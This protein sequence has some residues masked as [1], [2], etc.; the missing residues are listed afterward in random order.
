[1]TDQDFL[2]PGEAVDLDNCAREPI[3]V[4][5]RI[6]PRGALLALRTDDTLVTQC[7]KNVGA[8]LGVAPEAVLGRPLAAALGVDAADR[9]LAH[10][11]QVDDPR[12]RNPLD[13]ELV[14]QGVPERFEAVLH[15]APGTATPNRPPALVLELEPFSSD[16]TLSYTSTF[17][18]VRD[19]L[20]ELDHATSLQELYDVAVRRVRRLTGF[21]RV[22]LY[23]FDADYNGE[24]VA[25]ARREDLNAFLGLHYPASDIPPQA[26]ALYEKNWIRLISDVGYTPAEILP[27]DDPVSAQPLDLTYGTLRSVSPIHIEYLQNMGVGASMSISL[28]REGRLWGLIACHHYAGAHAPS[29]AARAAAEFLGSTLSARLVTQAE[30]DRASAARRSAGVLARLAALT[31][32]DDVTLTTALTGTPGLLDL[33]PADGAFVVAEGRIDRL[34]ETPDEQTCLRLGRA[35]AEL[36]VEVLVTDRLAHD[37]PELAG[38]VPD[39]A[40]LLALVVPGGGVTVWLRREVVQSVD[41]GG[42]PHNKAIARRE[43]DTVRLSPRRSF[44]RWREVVRGTSEPWAEDQVDVA[45][46]LRSYLAE[47]LL[48]RGRRDIRAATVLQRSL[49]PTSL[50]EVPGWQVDAR[51]EPSGGG[52]AGGDWYDALVLDDGRVAVVVGDVTGH[53]LAAAATMGQLRN[54]LRALLV[55][56]SSAVRAVEQVDHLLRTTLPGQVATLVVAVVSPGS[57]E[58]EYVTAGH[59]PPVLVGSDGA[60]MVAALGTPPLGVGRREARSGAA[61]VPAGGAVV[62]FSD[63]LVERRDES[64]VDG[65]GRLRAAAVETLDPGEL[66]ARVRDPDSEDDATVVVVRRD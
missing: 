46:S 40:G 33:V 25:E 5:G 8:V 64:I 30:D 23:R 27:T 35:L 50:P 65:L 31:R 13:L 11:A 26:R 17:E 63:G 66:V 18:P 38:I 6:Q 14:V 20:T 1:M 9:L 24:V 56:G 32:D 44:A 49:L 12:Q 62:L 10:V 41:W 58:V 48:L 3:H 39:A 42:D 57:G 47:G 37:E 15:H 54:A 52:L 29:Y 43:G 21:D 22:M 59:P 60:T 45:T 2:A 7:S 55:S 53:G 28:L 51:Y 61:A 36:D 4:P 34:G 16:T 19:A